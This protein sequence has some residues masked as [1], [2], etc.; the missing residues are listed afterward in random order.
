MAAPYVKA[1]AR[2]V[3]AYR[4]SKKYRD[5][6]VGYSAADIGSLRP[7]LQNYLACGTNASEAIDYYSLNAYEWCGA[8]STYTVSG[9]SQLTANI[10]SYNIP[11]FFSETGCNTVPPRDFADQAAIFGSDMSPYWS[12]SIIYE[13]IQE[14]NN[15][16]LVSYGPKVDPTAVGAPPDGFPRSGTPTPVS[17]DFSNLA[18]QWKTLTPTGVKLSAYS[19]TLTPPPCPAFTS[20][21]WEV[22]GNVGLPT[23]GQTF[24]AAVRSSIT[25]GTAAASASSPAPKKAAGSPAIDIGPLERMLMALGS[26]A[27]SFFWWL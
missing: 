17:P 11:I 20:G 15:Y 16:G 6:P 10:T 8:D 27:V 3:K 4:N 2:D 13:W 19:P 7:M 18:K 9:Y 26:V 23:L 1:A 5:I 12:G 22:N 24:D 25:A 21:V 14:T